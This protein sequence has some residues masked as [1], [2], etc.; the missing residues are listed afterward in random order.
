MKIQKALRLQKLPPYIF[1]KINAKKKEL[2]AAGADLIDLGMGDPDLD[3]PPAIVKT[4]IEAA[5]LGE[6][7]HYQPYQGIDEFRQAAVDWMERRFS[8]TLDPQSEAINLIGAKEGSYNIAQGVLNPG[9]FCLVPDPGYP[10]YTNAVV[11]AGATPTY[12]PL[13]YENRYRPNWSDITPDVWKATKMI[14]INFPNNPT[15]ASVEIDT[16]RE[17][18]DLAKRYEVIVV[19]DNPYS[20]HSFEQNAPA[21]MQAEGAKEVGI[22]IFSCSKTYNMTGWRVGFA[23]GN[24]ELLRALF[25]MKSAMDTGIFKPI[26]LS[27]ITALRGDDN[28]LIQPSKEVF[29]YRRKMVSENLREMGYEVFDGGSTFYLWIKTPSGESSLDFCSR[30]MDEKAVVT[31]PGVGF[32]KNGEGFFRISLTKP[33]EVLR[34]ALKRLRPG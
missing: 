2:K 1:S 10:V 29:R 5:Q 31:T 32:G 12:Y 24:E 28:E 13:Q 25:Q 7:H 30:M 17:L 16:Y 26:Q 15:G 21:F 27:A 11:L 33:E 4:L 6:N 8:V 14:Y 3:T 23:V 20:E 34:E 18:V 19:S 22:E 9:D